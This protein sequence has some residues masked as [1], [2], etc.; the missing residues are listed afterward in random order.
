MTSRTAGRYRTGLGEPWAA[1]Q[2]SCRRAEDDHVRNKRDDLRRD[3][4]PSRCGTRTA[5][6]AV[7]PSRRSA[8]VDQGE[9]RL[10]AG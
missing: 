5:G 6:L 10:L 7:A 2:R 8:Q 1:T 9:W 4:S 3:D